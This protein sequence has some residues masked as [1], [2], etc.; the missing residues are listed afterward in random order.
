MKFCHHF[1]K[2]R[3]QNS[4]LISGI[5]NI[6][7][8]RPSHL[9]SAPNDQEPKLHQA[10]EASSSDLVSKPSPLPDVPN[11]QVSKQHLGRV[12]ARI[13]PLLAPVVLP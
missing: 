12:W 5:P 3:T 1:F 7:E 10:L 8:P 9:V 11:S 13:P 6:Q 2:P 4:E